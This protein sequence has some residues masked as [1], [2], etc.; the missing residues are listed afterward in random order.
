MLYL[1]TYDL[2][3]P[4]TPSDYDRIAKA[5]KALGAKKVLLSTWMLRHNSSSV[6][7]RDHVRKVMDANDRLLVAQ[8][9][10]WASYN[11]MTDINT[12]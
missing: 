4:E 5:L 11:V 8:V 7:I 9:S 10:D 12:I 2:R 1:I 3:Q 6:A